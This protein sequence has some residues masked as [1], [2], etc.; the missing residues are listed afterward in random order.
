[1]DMTK[2]SSEA[3]QVL[4]GAAGYHQGAVASTV[5]GP[6]HIE[7]IAAGMVTVK[8]NLTRKGS[9]R[10]QQLKS[11]QEQELFPL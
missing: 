3:E 7:L 9:I 8:G 4:T 6:T 10:A 1:M 11:A 5:L 2:L